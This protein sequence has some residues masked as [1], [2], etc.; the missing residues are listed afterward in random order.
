MSLHIFS[1]YFHLT[2]LPLHSS[3]LDR[4]K[5]RGPW[6]VWKISSQR[7]PNVQLEG[8][9]RSCDSSLNLPFSH[10]NSFSLSFSFCPSPTQPP[11]F[12]LPF[13]Y[14]LF[15]SPSLSVSFCPSPSPTHYLSIYL[16]ICFSPSLSSHITPLFHS[17]FH[18]VC[19]S[20]QFSAL[21]VRRFM[22]AVKCIQ[23]NIRGFLSCKSARI[24]AV[25][26]IWNVVEFQFIKVRKLRT[27]NGMYWRLP[28]V[29]FE[30]L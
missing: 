26:K 12:F 30:Y 6:C 22:K 5:G 9:V 23:R 21:Y 4:G 29:H 28:S 1:P 10:S 25:Q 20:V 18:S 27:C 17:P 19:L 7:V 2:L 24:L 8:Y 3:R 13:S 15:L 16:Y 11:F 14:C